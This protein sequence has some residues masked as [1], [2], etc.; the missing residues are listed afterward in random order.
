[1]FSSSE[2]CGGHLV[3]LPPNAASAQGKV[4]DQDLHKLPVPGFS[5]IHL[6]K[7]ENRTVNYL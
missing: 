3:A 5:E 7:D 4:T 6:A 1:M 2:F